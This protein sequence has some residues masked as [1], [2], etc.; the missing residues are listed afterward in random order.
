MIF[1]I[2][3]D[4]FK[5]ANGMFKLIKETLLESIFD[6]FEQQYT[7]TKSGTSLFNY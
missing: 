3:N 1:N 5:S 7:V 6:S 2:Y 4:D